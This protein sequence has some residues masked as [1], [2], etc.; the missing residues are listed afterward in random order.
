MY[1]VTI[2]HIGLLAYSDVT[3][4]HAH[5]HLTHVKK[6]LVVLEVV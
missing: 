3:K 4:K 5:E 2:Y 6:A 1:Y